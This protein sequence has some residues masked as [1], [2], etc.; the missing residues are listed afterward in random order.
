MLFSTYRAV[1]ALFMRRHFLGGRVRY[2]DCSSTAQAAPSWGGNVT[3]SFGGGYW[4]AVVLALNTI[5]NMIEA[6]SLPCN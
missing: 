4:V 3:L 2:S 6:T 5:Y 1:P